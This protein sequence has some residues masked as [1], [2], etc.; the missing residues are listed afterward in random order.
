M[1]SGQ[2]LRSGSLCVSALLLTSVSDSRTPGVEHNSIRCWRRQLDGSLRERRNEVLITNHLCYEQEASLAVGCVGCLFS[3][4]S[5]LL[6]L[7][8]VI[9]D[10]KAPCRDS[11]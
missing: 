2:L 3:T 7:S 6:S 11:Q 10:G 5:A 4:L 1:P 8:S 9:P